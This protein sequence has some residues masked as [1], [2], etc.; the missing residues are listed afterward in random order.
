[1]TT[2]EE[3]PAPLLRTRERDC[4]QVQDSPRGSRFWTHVEAPGDILF[5]LECAVQTVGTGMQVRRFVCADFWHA[6][7]MHRK[8]AY[9]WAR[10]FAYFRAPTD[11][12]GGYSFE[13]IEEVHRVGSSN[14]SKLLFRF[15]SGLMVLARNGNVLAEHP[16]EFG[17]RVFP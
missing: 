16:L 3:A 7:D 8:T 5:I 2:F 17:K 4:Q 14:S 9:E 10:L 12:V 1:M 11:F 15:A 13:P 6:R